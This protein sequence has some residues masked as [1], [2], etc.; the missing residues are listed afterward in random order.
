MCD[1]DVE[2]RD[3]AR[4][5]ARQMSPAALAFLGDAVYE[6]RVRAYFVTAGR[7]PA[8]ELHRRT[9]GLVNAGFQARAAAALQPHLTAE[10]HAVLRRGRNLNAPHV[11]KNASPVSYRHATGL[12]AL[13]GYLY[14]CGDRGRLEELFSLV[15]GLYGQQSGEPETATAEDAKTTA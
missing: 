12:E 1:E 9:V 10:E 14:L 2:C 7:M 3:E 11:P 15:L 6:L 4:E 13:F 5:N 8:D